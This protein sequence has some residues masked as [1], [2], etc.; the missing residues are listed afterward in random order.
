MHAREPGSR[1]TLAA[2]RAFWEGH[3]NN[4]YYTG[5]AR[6]SDEFF[7]E[8]DQ[9][10]YHWHYHLVDLF[11]ELQGSSGRM[12]E[13]GCGMG[14]DSVRLARCGFEVTAIDLTEP[15]IA[16]ARQWAAR[17]GCAIDFRLGNAEAL[18]FPDRSFDAVYAFGVLHHT[19]NPVRAIGEVFRVLRP[20]GVA[21]IMLYHKVSL[22]H[23]THQLLRLPYESP[24]HYRD[25]CPIVETFTKAQA[26]RLFACFGDVTIR[27]CY[28]FTY[29]FR[30]VVSWIPGPARRALGRMVGWHLMIR[31]VRPY[32]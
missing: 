26:R 31:A 3:I 11:Q 4:E 21:H 20:G 9:R 12:L 18:E 5:A 25:H 30:S 24:G 6:G 7:A 13:I 16:L 8:I 32:E 27:V 1:A 29:G 28:P 15:A 17:A 22:V 10:R 19:P 2:V 14:M 23:L